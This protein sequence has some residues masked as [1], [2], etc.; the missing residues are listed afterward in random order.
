MT[1][2]KQNLFWAFAYNIILIPFAAGILYPTFGIIFRPEWS[3][4]AMALSSVTLIS[5]SLMHK[6]YIPSIKANKN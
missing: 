3:A 5:L 2:I 4:L 1:R 6:N